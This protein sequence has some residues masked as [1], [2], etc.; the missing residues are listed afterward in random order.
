[1]GAV[2]GD[3]LAGFVEH[4]V[5]RGAAG[6]GVLELAEG[7]ADDVVRVAVA[8]A[9]DAGAG[10]GFEVGGQVDLGRHGGGLRWSPYSTQGGGAVTF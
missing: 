7:G 9:G 5:E 8:A 4:G 2:A 3:F 6:F 10:E 1:M